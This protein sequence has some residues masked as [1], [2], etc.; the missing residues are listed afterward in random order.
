[1]GKEP[2]GVTGV[3]SEA[4]G[5]AES[6]RFGTDD[7]SIEPSVE[8]TLLRSEIDEIRSDLDIY[9]TEL[10]RRRHEALDVG[11]QVRK[12]KGILIVVGAGLIALT[13]GIVMSRMKGRVKRPQVRL[14]KKAEGLRRA[15][16]LPEGSS[17][18]S[19]FGKAAMGIVTGALFSAIKGRVE[20]AVD[21]LRKSSSMDRVRR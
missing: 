11:V 13:A 3:S 9:V 5:R 18:G 17:M 19:R 4:A 8:V 7:G 15:I 14:R 21:D 20:R 2:A 10:D 12:H 16:N 6:S 1:M